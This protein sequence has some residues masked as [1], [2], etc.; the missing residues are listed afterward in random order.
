MRTLPRVNDRVVLPWGSGTVE[1][2]V[3]RV[4]KTSDQAYVTIDVL[5]EGTDEPLRVTYPV[6]LIEPARAA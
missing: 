2:S 1:G 4:S 5:L 3:V 6:D